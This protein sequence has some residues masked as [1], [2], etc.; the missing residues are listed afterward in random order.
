MTTV[1]I[2]QHNTIYINV[3]F[4]PKQKTFDITN[5]WN[6]IIVQL[7]TDFAAMIKVTTITEDSKINNLQ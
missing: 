5:W 1:S 6:S 7:Q 3:V 4:V 2:F